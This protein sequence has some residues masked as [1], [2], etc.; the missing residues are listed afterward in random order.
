MSSDPIIC[1][2]CGK[3]ID[4]SDK[5]CPFCSAK[6]ASAIKEEEKERDLNSILALLPQELA[7]KIRGLEKRHEQDP[8][9][10]AVCIQLSSLYK[11]AKLKDRAV[12]YL[13]KAVALDPNNPYLKQK[14]RFLVDGTTTS[15]QSAQIYDQ[16]LKAT[17][18]IT[19]LI[20]ISIGVV[21]MIV[22]MII[23]YK[24]VKPSVFIIAKF[25]NEDA[26]SPQFSP[27]GDKVAF[28]KTPRTSLLSFVDA[29]A[30]KFQNRTV[31][32]VKDLKKNKVT[33]AGTL[34]PG[35]G[36][37]KFQWI[38]KSDNLSYVS[39]SDENLLPTVYRVSYA[40]EK[41][42]ALANANDFAWSKD[43]KKMAYIAEAIS[44]FSDKKPMRPD[45][46]DGAL[47]LM[48]LETGNSNI[49]SPLYCANP[50]F[51]PTESKIV[52]QGRSPEKAMELFDQLYAKSSAPT[53][54]RAISPRTAYVGDIYIHDI[55]SGE[56]KQITDEGLYQK[57]VF[58]PDGKQLAVLAYT[59][60]KSWDNTLYLM[61]PD[62]S[63]KKAL[64]SKGSEYIGFR[65]FSFSP[66]GK[67]MAF[68]GIFVN[69]EKTYSKGTSTPL[70]FIG[71][72]TN[73]VSDI[74]LLNLVDNTIQRL[75]Q[76]KFR[77]RTNP[78]FDPTGKWIA[79][80]IEYVDFRRE[81]WVEKIN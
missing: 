25:E 53:M 22:G 66:D 57:P 59:D 50:N 31:L 68:E 64:L 40:G 4:Q 13:E 48:D 2:S 54:G 63:G 65:K 43:G 26:V 37:Y 35:F 73:Y 23:I 81:A 39:I 52:F 1:Q 69:P 75:P 3:V 34:R 47:Y 77:Y 36:E 49:I 80:E 33:T 42:E 41:G 29:L 71:G 61:N 70:G 17:A 76:K 30:G 78:R 55:V 72:Q 32:M 67:T 45:E 8:N 62:G 12:H 16:Q 79:F 18:K 60:P 58:T 5:E 74:F 44:L 6:T 21:V 19:K 20:L 9:A 51:S 15:I 14:L 46:K 38:P 56:T 10:I 24:L 11:D 7:D 28:L 27:D